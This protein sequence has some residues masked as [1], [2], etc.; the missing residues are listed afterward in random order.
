MNEKQEDSTY[1]I[2]KESFVLMFSVIF[3]YDDDAV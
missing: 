3:V 2:E 1:I